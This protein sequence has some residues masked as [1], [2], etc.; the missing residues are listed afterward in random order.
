MSKAPTVVKALR[1][2]RSTSD[3]RAAPGSDG[4]PEDLVIARVAGVLV[5][6][7]KAAGPPLV[8]LALGLTGFGA[9]VVLS[10]GAS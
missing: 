4:T 6:I 9:A 10:R 1:E 7:V 8:V 2:R 3:G 5:D